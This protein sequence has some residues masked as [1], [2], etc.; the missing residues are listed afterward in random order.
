MSRRRLHQLPLVLFTATTIILS[1]ACGGAG[2]SKEQAKPFVALSLANDAD[3]QLASFVGSFCE[4]DDGRRARLGPSGGASVPSNAQ[5]FGHMANNALVKK[6]I[7]GGYVEVSEETLP[8]ET[9]EARHPACGKRDVCAGCPVI[10]KYYVTTY[11]LTS[12]G[13]SS[14]LVTPATED[15]FTRLYN[16]GP[17]NGP[18]DDVQQ[19]FS[20]DMPLRISLVVA[21]KAFDVTGVSTDSGKK[22]ARVNFEWYWKPAPRIDQTL[23][24]LIPSGRSRGSVQLKQME[25]GWHLDRDMAPALE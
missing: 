7:A 6:L 17:I 3:L 21:T 14:F 19:E 12:K 16:A 2:L 15:E 25:D 5:A 24:R 13:K 18:F 20:D 8:P 4:S 22:T 1:T 9:A 23:Q 11:Q 10:S